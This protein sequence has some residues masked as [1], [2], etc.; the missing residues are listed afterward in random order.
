MT[1]KIFDR[2]LLAGSGP[3]FVSSGITLVYILGFLLPWRIVCLVC[4]IFP[5]SSILLTKLVPES[6][7][8]LLHNGKTAEARKVWN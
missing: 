5:L 4:A 3:L 6:P 1:I 8:W 2:G 7:T